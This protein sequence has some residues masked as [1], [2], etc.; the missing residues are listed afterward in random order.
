MG[1]VIIMVYCRWPT[2]LPILEP[3]YVVKKIVSA[4]LTDQVYLYLPQSLYLIIF[5][6]K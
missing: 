6:K 2:F 1:N 3:N 5:L 4:I